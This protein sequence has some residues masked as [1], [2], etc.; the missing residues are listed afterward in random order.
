[1]IVYDE[2]VSG[3]RAVQT[4]YRLMLHHG[5]MADVNLKTWT[6]DLLKTE[7]MNRLAVEDAAASQIIILSAAC[8]MLPKSVEKWLQGWRLHKG[9]PPTA[10]IAVVDP[11]DDF[12]EELSPMESQL[13]LLT[14]ESGI[15][16]LIEKAGNGCEAQRFPLAAFV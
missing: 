11:G 2:F 3:Q 10:F 15:D 13:Q 4:Y 5:D 1:M 8:Q 14:A 9:K 7:E 12:D 16:F 6:F